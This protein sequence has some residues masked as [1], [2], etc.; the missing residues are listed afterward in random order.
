MN[1]RKSL[2]FRQD[3]ACSCS[4]R[5]NAFADVNKRFMVEEVKM[6]LSDLSLLGATF[7][8]PSPWRQ[9]GATLRLLPSFFVS[10]AQALNV[11]RDKICRISQKLLPYLQC[12]LALQAAK[13]LLTHLLPTRLLAQ[14]SARLSQPLPVVAAQTS[15][16]RPLL[17]VLQARLCPSNKLIFS[18]RLALRS[19]T[20]AN[21]VLP[22][23]GRAA[24]CISR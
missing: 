19:Y 4:A 16:P 11:E 20:I 1:S 6:C 9:S 10:A 22:D 13:Q 2:G 7:R 15:Q 17:A 5:P 14:R 18:Q 21:A 23:R 12:R 24:F 8:N 3:Q